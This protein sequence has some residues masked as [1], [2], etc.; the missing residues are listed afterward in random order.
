MST[1][2]NVLPNTGNTGVPY[3]GKEGRRFGFTALKDENNALNFITKADAAVLANWQ[4]RFDKPA[5]E[6]DVL[7]K[8]VMT[9]N[10]YNVI[11]EQEENIMY[12]NQAFQ[13]KLR[14]GILTISGMDED[15]IGEVV[16]A[17]KAIEDKNVAVYI[18]DVDTNVQ[19][20]EGGVNIYPFQLDSVSSQNFNM[21]SAEIPGQA[22][23]I[24]K[25]KNPSDINSI[26]AVNVADAE[27]TDD[28]DF[29]GLIDATMTTASPAVTGGDFTPTVNGDGTTFIPSITYNELTFTAT[30]GSGDETLAGAGSLS[31]N[32]VTGTYT[33]NEALLLT[34]GKTYHIKVRHAGYDIIVGTWAVPV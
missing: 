14:D 28:A 5:F 23:L 16:A 6:T 7:S 20:K 2:T 21:R 18:F 26:F 24:I 34:S 29:Y 12:Q 25:F 9:R 27:I 10:L 13:M 33:V 8:V 19:G 3:C 22:N 17:Y 30:D 31:Y 32:S 11:Q 1:G 15:T 4:A